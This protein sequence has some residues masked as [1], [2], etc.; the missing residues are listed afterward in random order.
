LVAGAAMSLKR[1]CIGARGAGAP[2]DKNFRSGIGERE[3]QR[4]LCHALVEAG[5]CQDRPHCSAPTAA[6]TATAPRRTSHRHHEK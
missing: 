2:I 1:I 4:E 3:S 6:T 5:H